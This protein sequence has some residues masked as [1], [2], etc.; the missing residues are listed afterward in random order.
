MTEGSI[1]RWIGALKAGNPAAAQPLW[2]AYFRRLVGLARERLQG[3]SR[4]MADEED[5]ALSTFDSV[6]SGAARGRFPQLSDRQNLWPL[7]VAIA[8][9]KCAD[10]VRLE[11]RVKRGG[12]ASMEAIDPDELFAREPSPE[13]AA[14]VA[15]ELN[16]R[17]AELDA[18]GDPDLRAITLAKLDGASTSEIAAQLG[19]TRRTVE[20]KLTLIARTWAEGDYA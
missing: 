10:L 20:R 9:N 3:A 6:C 19:C 18:A 1:T 15:D 8:R 16:H 14:Q 4:R 11:T 7:L 12:N 5:V 13:F 2:E 17:L